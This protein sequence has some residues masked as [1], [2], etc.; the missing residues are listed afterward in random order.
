MKKLTSILILA[1]VAV[2]LF[3]AVSASA[4]D[5][6]TTYTYSIDGE[7]LRSPTAYRAENVVDA[8]DMNIGKYTTGATGLQGA[9]DVTTDDSANVY[10]ADT[11]NNR[12]VILDK[13]YAAKGVISSYTDEFGNQQTLNQPEGVFVHTDVDEVAGTKQRLIYVCDTANFRIVVFAEDGLGGYV[14]YRTIYLVNGI[15]IKT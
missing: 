12:I 7:P 10:I 8:S 3:G 1:L 5:P 15:L 14:H 2:M 6:Y 9:K 13:Y 4:S 11:G